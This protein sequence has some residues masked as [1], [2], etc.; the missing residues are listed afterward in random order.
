MAAPSSPCL[1]KRWA[2]DQGATA[3]SPRTARPRRAAP[4][5]RTVPSQAPPASY[6]PRAPQACEKNPSVRAA[7]EKYQV[8]PA[9]LE[10]RCREVWPDFRI[11]HTLVDAPY[12][13]EERTKRLQWCYEHLNKPLSFWLSVVWVDEA[14]M[15]LEPRPQTCITQRGMR[16]VER[17]DRMPHHRFGQPHLNFW[18]AVNGYT[19]LCAFGFTHNT[20]GWEGKLYLVSA[21]LPA[22]A[23]RSSPK[24]LAS[25][26]RH[27]IWSTQ[28]SRAAVV[29]A[30][31]RLLP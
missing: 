26:V 19:G 23:P 15:V 3:A 31:T 12:T 9:Y 10:R 16:V 11:G 21:A 22:A 25:A 1:W 20:T 18:L 27:R 14:S 5:P 28:Q 13:L 6:G 24:S 8:T 7:C 2:G 29:A 30:H 17:D 4:T